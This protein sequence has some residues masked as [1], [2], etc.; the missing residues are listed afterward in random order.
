MTVFSNAHKPTKR[1][2]ECNNHIKLPTFLGMKFQIPAYLPLLPEPFPSPFFPYFLFFLFFF[3]MSSLGLPSQELTRMLAIPSSSL[4]CASSPVYK[5]SFVRRR[6][7]EPYMKPDDPIK[8]VAPRDIFWDYDAVIA[9]LTGRVSATDELTEDKMPINDSQDDDLGDD[10]NSDGGSEN[11]GYKS[12][13]NDEEYKEAP[14]RWPGSNITNTIASS[15]RQTSHNVRVV[16]RQ[17]R[18]A[19]PY[20]AAP[21]RPVPAFT[22]EKNPSTRCP[23]I[24]PITG[25]RCGETSK[26]GS[27]VDWT[28]RRHWTSVHL[29]REAKEILAGNLQLCEGTLISSQAQLDAALP[30]LSICPHCG[31]VISR[32]DALKRHIEKKHPSVA[33]A[34]M[35]EGTN[36]VN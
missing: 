16:K 20:G 25:V 28:S 8:T 31:S 22:L 14:V 13:L 7:P 4:I 36:I 30:R 3:F 26:D 29:L 18:R 11:D 27:I 15:T 23:Y 21:L 5:L 24:F 9:R 34:T 10:N 1:I 32:S 35:G 17:N 19:K 2:K 33:A 6:T 12:D